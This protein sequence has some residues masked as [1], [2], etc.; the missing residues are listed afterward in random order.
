MVPKVRI[1]QRLV[2]ELY[3]QAIEKDTSITS[4]VYSILD[5]YFAAKKAKA[6]NDEL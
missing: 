1:C 5:K 6:A 3:D 4:E 2:D